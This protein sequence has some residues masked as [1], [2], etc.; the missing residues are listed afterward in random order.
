LKD[1]DGP[2]T[3]SEV[4]DYLVA[5]EGVFYFPRARA[6]VLRQRLTRLRRHGSH[7]TVRSPTIGGVRPA[8]LEFGQLAWPE[9][10]I[11]RTNDV[12]PTAQPGLWDN[13]R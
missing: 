5:V 7:T 12:L 10:S 9:H 13:G 11:T 2:H 1:R 6:L 3:V 8:G 4:C